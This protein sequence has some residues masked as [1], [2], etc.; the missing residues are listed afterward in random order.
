MKKQLLLLIVTACVIGFSCKKIDFPLPKKLCQIKQVVRNGGPSAAGTFNYEYN[1][2]RLL[3]KLAFSFAFQDIL[4]LE[5]DN[6]DRPVIIHGV[7]FGTDYLIYQNN[8][9]IRVDRFGTN[10]QMFEQVFLTYDNRKRLIERKGNVF[11]FLLT[12]YEYEGNSKNPK[13][14]L[15][16]GL[17]VAAA[18]SK[19]L[20]KGVNQPEEQE[21][22]LHVI[23]EYKYDNKIN[24]QATLIGQPLSPF[25]FG[26][27]FIIDQYEP[28]PENNIVYQK[29]L[30]LS[31]GGFFNYMEYFITY[32]YDNHY[33]VKENH[34]EV[35]HNPNPGVP[36]QVTL[37][38]ATYVYECRN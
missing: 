38:T 10:G 35:F 6:Q 36:P 19:G 23:Y 13:R 26:Q 1:N 14:K 20:D 16:Y 12:R 21:L 15:L 24:P 9:L 18:V 32:E 29:F 8:L 5:Y 31:A 17:P 25:Y 30:G 2:E 34:K 37:A 28:I 27:E 7:N 11:G 22:Q 3:T 4:T 33:P